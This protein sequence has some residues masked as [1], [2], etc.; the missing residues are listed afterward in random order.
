VLVGQAILSPANRRDLIGSPVQPQNGAKA[1][2]NGAGFSLQSR[3]SPRGFAIT[4]RDTP[5]A[6]VIRERNRHVRCH[7]NNRNPLRAISQ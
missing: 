5:R 1:H 6:E 7:H 2:T 3:E 4:V